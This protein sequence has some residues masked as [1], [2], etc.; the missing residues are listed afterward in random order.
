[1]CSFHQTETGAAVA[2]RELGGGKKELNKKK[3][4]IH[5]K[6]KN[7]PLQLVKDKLQFQ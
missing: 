3:K 6:N 4:N 1:M 5:L 2:A 7:I